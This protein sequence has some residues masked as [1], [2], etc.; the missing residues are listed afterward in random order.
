MSTQAN[1]DRRH[2]R[3]LRAI[4]SRCQPSLEQRGFR[5]DGRGCAGPLCWVRIGRDTHAAAGHA[6]TLV[7]LVAHGR[8]ERAVVV[9]L[10][11]ADGVLEIQTPRRKRVQRYE[12]LQMPQVAHETAAAMCGWPTEP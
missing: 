7:L 2:D 8:Q 1:G 6:G 5:I 9:E 11:F 4:V 10:R 3:S 12:A